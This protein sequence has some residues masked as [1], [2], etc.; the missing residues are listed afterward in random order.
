MKKNGTD[1]Q[2]TNEVAEEV[3]FTDE[4]KDFYYG[5][6]LGGQMEVFAPMS[7]YY[8]TE[9]DMF[10][11]PNIFVERIGNVSLLS[12][13]MMA[14]A[15]P[16]I[17]ERKHNNYI[18]T[19]EY[20]YY[21]DWYEETKT[22]FSDGL[23]A[24]VP[25][26]KVSKQFGV[27]RGGR[28]Y[29]QMGELLNSGIMQTN[30]LIMYKGPKGYASTS[31]ISGT[32]YDRKR[33]M[34]YI[35]FNSDLK[36]YLVDIKKD[37]TELPRPV[38]MGFKRQFSYQLYKVLRKRLGQMM[39]YDDKRGFSKRKEYAFEIDLYELYFITSVFSLDLTSKSKPIL[40]AKELLEEEDFAGA[41]QVLKEAGVLEKLCEE[42]E[43]KSAISSYGRFNDK[44]LKKTFFDINGFEFI[45]GLDKSKLTEDSEVMVEYREK[46]RCN[47]PTELH[48]RYTPSRSG[49]G[50]KVNSVMFFVSWHEFDT[51]EELEFKDELPEATERVDYIDAEVYRVKDESAV[52]GPSTVSAPDIDVDD[53]LDELSE[54]IKEKMTYKSLRTIA[55][56][57]DYSIERAQKAYLIVEQMKAPVNDV[58]AFMVKA[59]KEHWEPNE[60]VKQ[61]A[62]PASGSFGDF[63]QR[64]YTEED[65]RELEARKLRIPHPDK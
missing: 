7:P 26:S 14:I 23:V 49:Y 33:G 64:R 25:M 20:Q 48:F 15:L 11:F 46:C 32:M 29:E 28:F 3:A 61:K 65:Y 56:A 43:T 36:P 35:K 21:K 1:I 4:Q 47:H 31:V 39:Y 30:W 58:V 5:E 44:L 45:K 40:K 27:S 18:G 60:T 22:D 2:S 42:K 17:Q 8:P 50:G 54:I 52:I 51:M 53:F 12:E 38:M 16:A 55:V 19:P 59:L 62:K 10:K 13:K 24:Q 63:P 57:A 9:S 37:F 34:V 41:A 6:D